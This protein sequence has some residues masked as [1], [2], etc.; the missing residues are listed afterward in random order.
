MAHNR[1][2]AQFAGVNLFRNF[3]PLPQL[4]GLPYQKRHLFLKVAILTFSLLVHRSESPAFYF[5]AVL[6]PDERTPYMMCIW[7]QA[8]IL[9]NLVLIY[10]ILFCHCANNNPDISNMLKN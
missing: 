3:H 7:Q 5:A 10:W 2:K 1:L 4:V 6:G 8:G 9:G